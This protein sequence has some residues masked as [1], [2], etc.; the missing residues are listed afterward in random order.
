MIGNTA[1]MSNDLF[2]IAPCR[3]GCTRGLYSHN[4]PRSKYAEKMNGQNKKQVKQFLYLLFWHY[5]G[6]QGYLLIKNLLFILSQ[7]NVTL[8]PPYFKI[9]HASADIYIGWGKICQISNRKHLNSLLLI[10]IMITSLLYTVL[11]C[12]INTHTRTHFHPPT[13]ANSIEKE[14]VK[15]NTD[16]FG[17]GALTK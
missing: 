13:T 16:L 5:L 2:V 1:K 7:P 6:D 17:N 3:G 10:M 12:T 9:S 8:K 11:K 4:L 14:N 15:Q